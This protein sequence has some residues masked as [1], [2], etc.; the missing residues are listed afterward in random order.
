MRSMDSVFV[1]KLQIG[2]ECDFSQKRNPICT[3]ATPLL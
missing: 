3:G 1:K 2:E